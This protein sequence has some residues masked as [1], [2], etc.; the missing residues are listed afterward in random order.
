MLREVDRYIDMSFFPGL[1]ID[2]NIIC[3]K[4][5]GDVVTITKMTLEDKSALV[6]CLAALVAVT[7]PFL[8]DSYSPSYMFLRYKGKKH[9]G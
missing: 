9:A 6:A 1:K 4:N 2:G 7:S 8:A 5:E 3:S